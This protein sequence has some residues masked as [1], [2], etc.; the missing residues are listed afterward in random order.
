MAKVYLDP[1]RV[2]TAGDKLTALGINPTLREL[3]ND[4]G[5]NA[6]A[7]NLLR[8][9]LTG[10]KEYRDE[11]EKRIGDLIERVTR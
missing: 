11:S 7:W 5:A 2:T 8:W 9:V 6:K 3:L 10:E 4:P 1:E